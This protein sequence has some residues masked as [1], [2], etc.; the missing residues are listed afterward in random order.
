V[1]VDSGADLNIFDAEIAEV[2]GIEL[3]TGEESPF[4][5]ISGEKQT[6]YIHPVSITVGGWEYQTKAGF[7]DLPSHAY[8]I[9]GQKGFFSFFRITF[10]Y[11][12]KKL[13]IKRK[14]N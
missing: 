2:I 1:L 5:G 9:V 6:M 12:K 14:D 7:A 8:G 3:E 4:A 13:Y 10:D 11:T